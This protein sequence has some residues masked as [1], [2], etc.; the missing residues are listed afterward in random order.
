MRLAHYIAV[1]AALVGVIA[2]CSEQSSYEYSSPHY[3]PGYT[4]PGAS[5]AHRYDRNRNYNGIHPEA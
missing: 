5:Y 1:A 4:P 3:T 2:G